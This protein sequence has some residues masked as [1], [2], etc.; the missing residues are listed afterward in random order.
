MR[1]EPDL[2]GK[3]ARI[4]HAPHIKTGIPDR[5][6]VAVNVVLRNN[7]RQTLLIRGHRWLVE[8]LHKDLFTEIFEGSGAGGHD[9]L[10]KPGQIFSYD[11]WLCLPQNARFHVSYFGKDGSNESFYQ[12]ILR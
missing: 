3:F 10:L 2:F 5:Q 11:T 7:S 6:A 12:T 1:L 4:S 8:Y 9:V